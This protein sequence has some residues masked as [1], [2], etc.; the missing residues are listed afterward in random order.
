MKKLILI[1]FLFLTAC[2]PAALLKHAQRDIEK[3]KIKGAKIEKTTTFKPITFTTQGSKAEFNTIIQQKD[4]VVNKYIL[5]DT[6]IVKN[7]IK[8]IQKD[9]TIYV[10]CPEETKTVEVP[11][12]EN[13]KI[14]AGYTKWQYG[15]GI[16]GGVL[17][18]L[19]VG[20]LLGKIIKI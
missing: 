1:G 16:A 2:G 5:K 15:T 10:E 13:L 17:F 12:E 11:V 4:G 7:R 9:S 20:F 8:F 19:V 3:A 14:S 18:G 6:T